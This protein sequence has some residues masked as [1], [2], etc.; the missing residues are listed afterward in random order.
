MGSLASNILAQLFQ[1]VVGVILV[2]CAIVCWVTSLP[3]AERWIKARFREFPISCI[4]I[5]VG[6]A[7]LAALT[8]DE[9]IKAYQR[10]WGA[11][12]NQPKP[13]CQS[14]GPATANGPGSIANSG[15][16]NSNF[17]TGIPK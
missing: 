17:S 8:V 11:T 2:I 4:I 16:D 7:A 9:S 15:C 13:G 5:A 10:Q 3:L 6:L 1:P 12:A 14:T